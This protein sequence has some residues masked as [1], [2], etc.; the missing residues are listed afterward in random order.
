MR[1]FVQ[2]AI[3]PAPTRDLAGTCGHPDRCV[4]DCCWVRLRITTENVGGYR[5]F[6]MPTT[7]GSSW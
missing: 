3:A 4:C 6:R 7:I 5:S 2:A 1:Q